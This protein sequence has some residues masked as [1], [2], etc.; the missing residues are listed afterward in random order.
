VRRGEVA[1]EG[2]EELRR[3]GGEAGEEG[4]GLEEG[5]GGC[6][7]EGGPLVVVMVVSGLAV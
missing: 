1:D 7:G 3:D 2:E 6:E 4:E 5:E